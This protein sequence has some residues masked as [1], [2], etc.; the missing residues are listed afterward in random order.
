MLWVGV[1]DSNFYHIFVHINEDVG[2]ILSD[3]TSPQVS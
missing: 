1:K 3:W 2:E